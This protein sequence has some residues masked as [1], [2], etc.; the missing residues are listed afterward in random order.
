MALTREVSHLRE[1]LAAARLEHVHYAIRDIAVVAE[2]LARQGKEILPLNIGD[3]LKFDFR[4]P[5]HI[6]EAVVRAMRDGHDGYAPSQGIDEALEAIRADAG[7]KGIRSIQSVFVTQGVSE[8][9][10]LCLT[11]LVNPGENV[12]API[13]E[14]PLYSAVLSKLEA[15]PN[16]YALDE[17]SGWEPDLGDLER[18]INAR[19]RAIVVIN[20]NNPTGA[21]YSRATLEAIAEQARRHG[22]LVIA[23]E[24][25]DKLILDGEPRVSF[26]ALAPDLPVVTLNGLSKAYLAPG[27]RV[28]WVVVSGEAAAVKSYVE[29]I[30]KLLRARL[31]AN[32]PEQY[33]VRP[34]LEGPQD[35][36]VEVVRKLRARRDLTVEW[37]SHTERVS[38]V[39]PRGAFYAFPRLEIAGNDEDFVRQ[40]LLEK[41]VMV[42]HGSGFGQAPGTKHFRIVFLPEESTLARAYQ[43][44]GDFLAT[45]GKG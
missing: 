15:E 39:T 37:C 22:L 33:A 28:G 19:T 26:A 2:Q 29:G 6:V 1:I 24:I 14:Y 5:P 9:V 38:C 17:A 20:P 3:P 7:R 34:A 41:Q 32:H 16:T 18:R 10:D 31:S 43:A 27:W 21:V 12:L 42:V 8:A 35:H 11:A 36:L 44:I 13:P 4:T 30:H 45:W 40:L 25:Y 23:D